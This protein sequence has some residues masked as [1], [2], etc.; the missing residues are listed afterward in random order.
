L[1]KKELTRKQKAMVAME[2]HIRNRNIMSGLVFPMT[3]PS[4]V[5]KV[6]NIVM[7]ADVINRKMKYL[8]N[9]ATQCSQLFRPIIFMDS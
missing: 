8:V 6:R 9:Q 1:E 5:S 7:T 2:K 3:R 4:A